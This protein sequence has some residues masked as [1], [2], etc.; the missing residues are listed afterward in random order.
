M[1]D[2]HKIVIC[3]FA[4]LCNFTFLATAQNPHAP[5]AEA[6]QLPECI[7][8]HGDDSLL[9]RHHMA[10]FQENFRQGK[11]EE[12]YANW[13]YLFTHAPCSYKSIHQRGPQILVYMMEHIQDS[14]RRQRLMDTLFMIF[15]KRMMY[16][17]EEALVKGYL[18][19]YTSKYKPL[20]LE[21]IITNYAFYVEHYEGKKD[22]QYVMDF[23]RNTVLA[24]KN[25][26]VD[27][28]VLCGVYLRLKE[29]T[30]GAHEGSKK[31]EEGH[32]SWTPVLQ[33]LDEVMKDEAKC[34]AIH[35]NM[36]DKRSYV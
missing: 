32:T 8:S 21:A 2:K 10:Y 30:Q 5:I 23:M 19:W 31:D 13:S 16:F 9:T 1:N 6:M 34:S 15:P 27:K 11:Y 36:G 22:E 24:Y 26:L 18:A 28:D 29:L 33:Y 4:L 35:S 3:I 12:A 17:G 20:E 7:K 25:T 14:M